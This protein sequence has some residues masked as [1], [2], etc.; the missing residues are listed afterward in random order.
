[1]A[2][3]VGIVRVLHRLGLENARLKW[4]NDILVDNHKLGGILI[5]TQGDALG[6]VSVVVGVGLNIQL[7]QLVPATIAQAITDMVSH[8]PAR[9]A[10][11][12]LLALLLNELAQVA[13]T[14]SEAGFA[15]FAAEWQTWHAWQN[16]MVQITHP[17]GRTHHGVL[18]GIDTQGALRIAHNQ[19][20][21]AVLTADITLLPTLN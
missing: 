11:N 15:A 20:E 2:V 16:K 4:P 10:R 5:E 6:P 21:E 9:P 17:N 14:F 18:R 12:A 8:L 3:G 7:P 19:T 13:E 1:M